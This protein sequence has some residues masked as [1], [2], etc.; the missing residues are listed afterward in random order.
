VS[1]TATVTVRPNPDAIEAHVAAAREAGARRDWPASLSAWRL[2]LE[3]APGHAAAL[4]GAAT[5][6]REAGRIDEAEALLA[7][8]A[9][10]VPPNRIVSTA[11]AALAHARADWPVAIA[12]WSAVQ[13]AFPEHAFA[14]LRGAQ[15]LRAAS[16][17]Q[18]AER[19]LA[20]AVQRFPDDEPLAMARAWLANARSDWPLALECWTRLR[21][22]SPDNPSVLV[23]TVRALHGAGRAEEAGPL[24]GTAEALLPAARARGFDPV[25][26]QRLA[27]DIARLRQ[28]WTQ[29]RARA[30]ELLAAK[31]A[32]RAEAWLAVAQA[33]W[34]SGDR[35]AADAAASRAL[36]I[37]PNLSEAVLVR[38]WVAADRGDGP[39][40]ID[41]YRRVAEL[42][43]T[44]VRWSLKLVQLLNWFGRIDEAVAELERL[45]RLWPNN[46]SVLAYL[47]SYGPTGEMRNGMLDEAA[48][49]SAV[50]VPEEASWRAIA[51]KAP[52]EAAWRRPLLIDDPRQD[53]QIL[54][55]DGA[56][57][58]VVLFTNDSDTLSMP[59]ALF[60]RFMAPL[61]VSVIYLKDFDRLRYLGG[62]RSLAATYEGALAALRRIIAGL[63]AHRVLVLGACNGGSAAIRYGIELG[64]ERIVSFAAATRL[65]PEAPTRLRQKQNFMRQ[66]LSE[67]VPDGLPDLRP[68]LESHGHLER[69][70]YFYYANDPREAADAHHLAELPGIRFHPNPGDPAIP[71][72][73]RIAVEEADFSRSLA[74]WLNLA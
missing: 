61:P 73:R 23:G 24:L 28:D 52:Q 34:H 41:L 22:R 43:P 26:A 63:G 56:E 30:E 13:L 10:R 44:T 29:L 58:V 53:V 45:R 12:R 5:A 1:A 59:L 27:L 51:A 33:S 64:A 25:A 69:I 9:T 57:T 2:V 60:D 48:Q 40:T 62:I 21:Q 70:A 32:P 54:R 3:H 66:R 74:T 17:L 7:G 11:Y 35:D 16:R 38:I 8:P 71:L 6:L 50:P 47:R 18:E 37:D 68:F 67:A 4:A 42:N 36:D 55:I 19:L 31:E 39:A 20:D 72:L 65:A 14:F 15:A 49:P 46:P